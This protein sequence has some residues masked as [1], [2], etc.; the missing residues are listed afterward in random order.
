MVLACESI[1]SRAGLDAR[2]HILKC[3]PKIYTAY[4]PN[5]ASKIQFSLALQLYFANSTCPGQWGKHQCRALN[6]QLHVSIIC[7]YVFYS[8]VIFIFHSIS[9]IVSKEFK[10]E[11]GISFIIIFSAI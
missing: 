5:G 8:K 11:F 7:K 4:L 6:P 3:K 1:F 9:M 10:L 2:P